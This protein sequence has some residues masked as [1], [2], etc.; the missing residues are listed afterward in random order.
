LVNNEKRAATEHLIKLLTENP[1]LLEQYQ[2][3]ITDMKN[4][5]QAKSELQQARSDY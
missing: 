1:E 2:A 3:L 5:K 4:F